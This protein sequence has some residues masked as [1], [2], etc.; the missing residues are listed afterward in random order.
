MTYAGTE[1]PDPI[2]AGTYFCYY[3]A[4]SQ[5]N[6]E[7]ACTSKTGAYGNFVWRSSNSTCYVTSQLAEMSCDNL[8]GYVYVKDHNTYSGVNGLNGGCY[9]TSN[10]VK[11][12]DS[13]YTLTNGKCIKTID[14]TLK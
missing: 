13:E 3:H 2:Y 11:Y 9:P 6:T 7:D 4:I 10:K 12:C 14:A 1:K 5:Y 8:S